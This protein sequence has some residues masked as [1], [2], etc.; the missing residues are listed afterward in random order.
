MSLDSNGSNLPCKRRF[1]EAVSDCTQHTHTQHTN[2]G[3][4]AQRPASGVGG[5]ARS[6]TVSATRQASATQ[7]ED[8]HQQR[9]GD[10]GEC[11]KCLFCALSLSLFSV[12]CN[13]HIFS[14]FRKLNDG[15][16]RT[17][18]QRVSPCSSCSSISTQVV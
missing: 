17:N 5:A 10:V 16:Q 6:E 8:E 2:T 1:R 9:L 13:F 4:L 11:L 18:V 3:L 12:F 15:P 7:E 14:I